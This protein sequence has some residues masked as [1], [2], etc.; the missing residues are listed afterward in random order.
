MSQMIR[1]SSREGAGLQGS[2]EGLLRY[3]KLRLRSIRKWRT[4]GGDIALVLLEGRGGI[5]YTG[6]LH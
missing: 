2:S 5:V 6:P 3:C 4:E 1:E